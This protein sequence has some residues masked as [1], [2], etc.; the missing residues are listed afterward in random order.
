MFCLADD[1]HRRVRRLVLAILLVWGGLSLR[2]VHIQWWNRARFA[3]VAQRQQISEEVIRARPGDICDRRGRLLATTIVVPSFFADPD[4]LENPAEFAAAVGPVLGLD[5]GELTARLK[6]YRDKR[7]LWIKRRL[8]EKEL[9]ALQQLKLSRLTCGFKSEF[10]RHY[11]QGPIAAHILGLR[12]ID[13]NGRG[14]VEQFFDGLIRGEDGRRRFVRD[15]RGY[16]LDVLEEVTDSPR[17][18][19]EVTLTIDAALQVQ[20]EQRL[21]T[22][23]TEMKPQGVCGIILD[24]VHGEVLAMASRPAFDPRAPHLAEETAWKNLCIAAVFEPGSTFKPMVV[25]RAIDLGLVK[26]EESLFCERGA[27]RMG[28]RVLHD[29]HRYGYLSVGDVLVKS[30]NIGMAKIG[31]RMGN[32]ELYRMVTEYGF[33]QPTGIELPGELG[34]FLRPLSEWNI[35]STGSIPMGQEIATTPLQMVAAHATLANG[36]R[37]VAPHLLLQVNREPFPKSSLEPRVASAESA[38][39]LVKG[40]MV[41]VVERGTGTKAKLPGVAVFGKTGTA[42]KVDP[43]TGKYS[44]QQHVSS[45]ICG[46][47]AESPRALV[48]I[49]VDEPSAEAGQYGGTVAAP[50]AADVLKYT[51]GYLKPRSQVLEPLATE[52]PAPLR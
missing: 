22:L 42:Q 48:L 20:L 2:L 14:G 3:S 49:T 9:L 7:F 27:Y 41:D 6:R 24:P 35:Y 40:P 1:T 10:Q 21:D 38:F 45:F 15:A 11:P 4:R 33:G 17:D 28:P 47:P 26:P 18:G 37:R 29:H 5:V 13:G 34:G 50:A 31:E 19:A 46:A 12:D 23:M 39:W 16:V 51:L 32:E 52:N 43:E 8:T 36:G 25:G 30:S 44:H